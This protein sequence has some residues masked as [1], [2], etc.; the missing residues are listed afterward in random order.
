MYTPTYKYTFLDFLD[1]TFPHP[2]E[3]KARGVRR[4]QRMSSLLEI[5]KTA[6]AR[7]AQQHKL[8]PYYDDQLIPA[9]LTF[10]GTHWD[11]P[12]ANA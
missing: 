3:A 11:D 8:D 4:G 6:L 5:H 9:F 10:I 1:D 2:P 12:A 7:C